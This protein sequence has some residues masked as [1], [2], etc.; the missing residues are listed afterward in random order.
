MFFT[1]SGDILY[2]LSLDPDDDDF[3]GEK[4]DSAFKIFDA[5]D[6]SSISKAGFILHFYVAR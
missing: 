4:R 3:D 5:T 6:Y 2:A 1:N